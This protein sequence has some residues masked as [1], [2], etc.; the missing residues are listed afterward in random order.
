M[1]VNV[2]VCVYI[3]VYVCFY[4]YMYFPVSKSL[5]VSQLVCLSTR[6]IRELCRVL[7][8]NTLLCQ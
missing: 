8:M 5:C 4:V 1:C 6:S 7:C 3:C 2:C